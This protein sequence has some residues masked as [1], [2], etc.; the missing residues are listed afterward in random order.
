MGFRDRGIRKSE[1]VEKTQFLCVGKNLNYISGAIFSV[2]GNPKSLFKSLS[3]GGGASFLNG[4]Q[5]PPLVAPLTK[6]VF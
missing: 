2:G 4:G 6:T 5:A 1:I 3:T